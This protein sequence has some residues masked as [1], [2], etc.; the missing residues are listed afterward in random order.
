MTWTRTAALLL[1]AAT[2]AGCDRAPKADE[3]DQ[4][5][6]RILPASV[7]DAMLETDRSQVEPPVAEPEFSDP[8]EGLSPGA[9]D[10]RGPARAAPEPAGEPGESAPPTP[11][12]VP[13]PETTPAVP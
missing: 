6:G 2:A 7:S 5:A 9:P 3:R 8:A 12:P 10:R 4:A 11:Q 1:L 13:T